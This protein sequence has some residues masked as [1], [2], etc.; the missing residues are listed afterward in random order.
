MHQDKALPDSVSL[1]HDDYEWIQPL[2]YEHVPFHCRKCHAHEHL[3]RDYLL[4]AKANASDPYDMPNQDGFAKVP[5]RKRAHKKPSTR[6]KPQQDTAS[7]PS[8]SNSFEILAKASKEKP[9]N[10]K[11]NSM[12]ISSSAQPP[13]SGSSPTSHSSKGDKTTP[14]ESHKGLMGK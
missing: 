6:K 12:P 7:F 1:F 4:N 8:T 13:P 11:T 2:D 10:S 5:S 9:L 3:F 14:K